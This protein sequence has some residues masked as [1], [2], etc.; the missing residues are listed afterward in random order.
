MLQLRRAAYVADDGKPCLTVL[1]FIGG[2]HANFRFDRRWRALT[3][4]SRRAITEAVRDDFPNLPSGCHVE[5]DRVAKEVVLTNLKSALPTSKAGLVAELRQLGD[6]SLATFLRETG[7]EIEDVYRSASIG[8]LLTKLEGDPGG[9]V[10]FGCPWLCHPALTQVI[11]IQA[12]S[13]RSAASSHP[14]IAS[15]LWVARYPKAS[16]GRV[17]SM[18]SAQISRRDTR[19]RVGG[20]A[21]KE[22]LGEPPRAPRRWR[23]VTLTEGAAIDRWLCSEPHDAAQLSSD[24]RHLDRRY[25]CES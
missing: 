15:M 6:V 2:Q 12:I 8:G 24:R 1:D 17:S 11:S 22:H 5:L 3:G 20:S 23:H 7:L 21:S 13:H 9:L 25:T 18:C 10:C 14:P 4:V 19:R 16:S